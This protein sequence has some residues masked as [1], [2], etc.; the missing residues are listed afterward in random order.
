VTEPVRRAP[1]GDAAAEEEAHKVVA[2]TFRSREGAELDLIGVDGMISK[3]RE[4]P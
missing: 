4:A 3:P 2:F 1:G